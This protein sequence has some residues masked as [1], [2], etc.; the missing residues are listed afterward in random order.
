MFFYQLG[1]LLKRLGWLHRETPVPVRGV[2]CLAFL[3]VTVV[4]TRYTSQRIVLMTGAEYVD[5]GWFFVTSL[6]GTGFIV[7]LS[8]LVANS[9]LINYVGTITLALMCLDG[10]LHEFVNLPVVKLIVA[11]TGLPDVLSLTLICSLGTLVSLLICWPVTL[12]LQRWLPFM[13]GRARAK[14]KLP[15]EA[16]GPVS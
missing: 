13:L 10:I 12:F 11:Q 1:Y 3:A 6:A 16:S 14:P 7:Y 2:L 4:A 8:Q 9:R 5:I 15:A